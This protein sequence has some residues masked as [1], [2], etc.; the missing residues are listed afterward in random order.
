MGPKGT[1]PLTLEYFCFESDEIWNDSNES[2]IQFAAIELR[3]IFGN[4]F[5]I[6]HS[7]LTRNPKGYH[8]IRLDIRIKL[9]K[10]DHG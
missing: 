6:V 7:D 5:E 4:N 8:V 10:L 9:K 2:I 3:Q 1:Y